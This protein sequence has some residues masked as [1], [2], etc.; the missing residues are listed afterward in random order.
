ME[1]VELTW[2][3]GCHRFRLRIGELRALQTALDAGP[4]E[5]FNRLRLG[6]WRVDD[7]VQV[8]RWGLVG[9]E[10]MSA[11][12]A[13]TFVTPLIDLHPASQFKMTALAILA[14]ALL[15]DLG[16]AVGE[17]DGGPETPPENSS[18]PASTAQEP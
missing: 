16:D 5:V 18:S 14:H 3:G 9:A 12:D 10:E 15:G 1:S 8:I 11:S 17:P 7:L 2:P 13:A 4:E 6:T